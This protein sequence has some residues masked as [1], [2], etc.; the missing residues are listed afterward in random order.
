MQGHRL[1]KNLWAAL[2]GLLAAL[3]L[4]FGLL[5][6]SLAEPNVLMAE[7]TIL[8]PSPVIIDPNRSIEVGVHI[9]NIW[10]LSLKDKTFNCEGWYWLKWPE[11]VQEIITKNDINLTEIVEFTNQVESWNSKIELDSSKP[12]R[13]PDG[14]FRQLV[15]FSIR[16][17]DDDENLRDFPFQ[18]LS[19]PVILETRPT[20]FAVGEN[21]ILLNPK[22]GSK[23]VVGDYAGLQGFQQTGATVNNKIHIYKTNFGVDEAQKAGEF[24]Q[25]TFSLDY[26][27]DPWAAFYQY[28]LPWLTVMAMLLMAPNLE[29]QF[30]ELRLAIPSTALLTM[31]FLQQ[32]ARAD[33]PPLDYLTFLDK[34]YLFGFIASM[35]LFALFVWGT[36]TYSTAAPE[37]QTAVM[38]RINRVDLIFQ[39]ST[40]GGALLI[41]AGARLGP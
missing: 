24:S 15:R 33:L 22:I 38:A 35:V 37:Q 12:D 41:V 17:Y 11:P 26:A 34:L 16:L 1:Q 2:L 20:A 6:P 10:G 14:R 21:N 5:N 8:R 9:E 25:V 27:T 18:S 39:I 7:S 40:I 32:S 31:V 4:G 36:N 23:G 29:G 30:T 28:I 19:L 13:Q 3:A